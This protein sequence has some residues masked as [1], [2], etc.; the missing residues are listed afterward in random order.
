MDRAYL[1][2]E[3]LYLRHQAG[4]V[5]VTR[6]KSN[7][8]TRRVSSSR[9][10]RATGVICDQAIALNGFYSQ[11]HDPTHLRRIR[12]KGPESGKTL[13]FLTNQTTLPALTIGALYKSRRQ[14]ELF[15]KWIKQHLRI[16]R[17][18][19]MSENAV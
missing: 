9:T 16:T 11:Q 6:A 17:F 15:F 12:V 5:F 14:V 18:Y 10:D 3:R 13:R 4:S 2:C 1:D 8:D 19:V 7:L